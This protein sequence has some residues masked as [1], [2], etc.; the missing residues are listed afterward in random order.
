M[1]GSEDHW[2]LTPAWTY[3]RVVGSGELWW[4]N[5][6]GDYPDGSTWHVVGMFQ[7]RDGKV[8]EETWYFGPTLEAPA[9][10]AAWMEPIAP[11]EG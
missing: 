9:R 3:Q 4:M 11:S 10:R 2:V 8:H 1:H 5:G 6:K 7:V